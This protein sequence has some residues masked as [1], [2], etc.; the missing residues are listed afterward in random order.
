MAKRN[1]L[2][3]FG[4]TQS[5]VQKREGQNGISSVHDVNIISSSTMGSHSETEVAGYCGLGFS[6][7]DLLTVESPLF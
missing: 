5:G 2:K 1:K 3:R 7:E 6:H 4:G